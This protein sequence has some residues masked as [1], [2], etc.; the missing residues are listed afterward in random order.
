M[1][2]SGITIATAL[3]LCCMSLAA[4]GPAGKPQQ[5]EMDGIAIIGDREL[6]NV[7][8]VVPWKDA[9][10]V[11]PAPPPLARGGDL[12]PGHLERDAVQRQ[13]RRQQKAAAS[14]SNGDGH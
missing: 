7:L 3:L 13:L 2:V 12:L 6:P 1:K 8:Y 9:A 4:Q 14:A 10:P 5:I 11:A